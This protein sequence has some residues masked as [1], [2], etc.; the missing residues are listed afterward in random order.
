MKIGKV[1][2]TPQ[3]IKDFVGNQG[4]NPNDYLDKINKVQTIWIIIPIVLFLILASMLAIWPG[5]H[6]TIK[7][8]L[9]F[10]NML[11]I[12]W[13]SCA[14]QLKYKNATV[15]TLCFIVTFLILSIALGFE[16]I[17]DAIQKIRDTTKIMEK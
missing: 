3:E 13:F 4:F 15:T 6:S 11:L 2:G 5:L 7:I 17:E 16:K 1:E 14:I 10:I 9:A 8:I 12:L